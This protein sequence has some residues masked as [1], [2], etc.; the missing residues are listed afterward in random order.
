M[1]DE[2][3]TGLKFEGP[4]NEDILIDFPSELPDLR[5]RFERL[6]HFL[7]NELTPSLRSRVVDDSNQM[8]VEDYHLLDAMYT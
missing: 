2:I 8:W 1:G 3:L 5:R 6:R 4:K 7:D